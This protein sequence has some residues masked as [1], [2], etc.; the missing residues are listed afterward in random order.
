MK[1]QERRK[2]INDQFGE[3]LKD[4]GRFFTPQ[5]R[6]VLDEIEKSDGHFDVEELILQI[7]QN[8]V[9]VSRA[10]V[11]RTI[12]HLERSG[13]IR[14]I[15]L[16]EPHSHYEFIPGS[17]EHEHMQ[18]ECCGKVIEFVDPVIAERIQEIAAGNNFAVS[19][20]SLQ[21][22]GMCEECLRKRDGKEEE[23]Q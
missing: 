1:I 22:F 19:R 20:R 23:H 3:Y 4:H 8:K 7:R 14:K 21:I 5:R 12:G 17:R 11:Y 18:C 16:D 2:N 10:T 6:Q 13:F 15:S 9:K